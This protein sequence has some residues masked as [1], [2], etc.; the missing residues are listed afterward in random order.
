MISIVIV[1]IVLIVIIAVLIIHLNNKHSAGLE[2]S[3]MGGGWGGWLSKMGWGW[4]GCVS[5]IGSLNPYTNY[6]SKF[7]PFWGTER[8]QRP[9][10]G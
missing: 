8:D 1:F 10:M 7:N 3:E 5:E 6:V 2:F 9:E 4:G